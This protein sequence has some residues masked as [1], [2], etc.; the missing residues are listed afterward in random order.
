MNSTQRRTLVR[1]VFWTVVTVGAFWYFG[2]MYMDALAS[3][4]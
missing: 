4:N 1:R 3:L 2:A